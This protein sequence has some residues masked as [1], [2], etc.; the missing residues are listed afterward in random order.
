[1][2]VAEP[3]AQ[4]PGGAPISRSA[5]PVGSHVPP[6]DDLLADPARDLPDLIGRLVRRDPSM[7][8]A[9][10]AGPD[11][12][13][14]TVSC[15]DLVH[16]VRTLAVELAEA[17][18]ARGSC[19]A[20][21]LPNWSDVLVWQFAVASRGAHVIGINT[22]YNVGEVTHVLR[23]ARPV[24]LAVA[25]GFHGLDLLATLREAVAAADVPAPS[26]AVVS[27]PGQS[28]AVGAHDVG[29][30][31]VGAGSWSPAPPDGSA[32]ELELSDLGEL[33]AAFT[34]SGSTG[35]PK[36]AAH[37]GSA[38]LGHAVADA[39]AIGLQRGDVVLCALPLAGVF[40]F[41][42]AMATL[43]AGGVCLLVPVFDP[44]AVLD[45]MA[46]VGVTH[47]V[48]GDDLVLR[49]HDAWQ[50]QPR[51]L[52]SW[53]WCGLANFQGRAP[54][55]ARWARDSFG[56]MTSGVYGS[57]EVFALTSMWPADEPEPG[58]WDAGGRVAHPGIAVRTVDPATD[59]VLATGEEGELQFRG[60]NVVD[61]YLGDPGAA[62]RAS[63]VDGWFRSG[64]LGV[65]LDEG[66]FVYVC[67]IGDALRLRGFLVDPAEIELRLTEHPGVRVAKVVGVEAPDGAT[68]AVAFVVVGVGEDLP[69]PEELRQ[70]CARS[71]AAFKVPDA[72]HLVAELP[73]VSGPNGTKILTSALREWA[74][75][76]HPSVSA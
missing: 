2:L 10:D 51:D 18:V 54:E 25:D 13:R 22:R 50:L 11:G 3:A 42:T 45:A 26:I 60:P 44:G 62:A 68:R 48:G 27:G 66:A 65:L 28:Q 56:T 29:A 38:V 20:V 74:H 63:T 76:G 24:V 46:Q 59:R 36:L 64:D 57:S 43:A 52:S 58:R 14:I 40:G 73:T 34:T 61:A 17:G 4:A 70:W 19:V 67:R 39:A 23:R 9:I 71:L 53:R 33:A 21:W 37:R 12:E 75:A 1:M 31:D 47:V 16:R 32:A 15:G 30:Y 35:R 6:A 5:R 8:V 69:S 41:N 55:L 49:L 72:V 7:V